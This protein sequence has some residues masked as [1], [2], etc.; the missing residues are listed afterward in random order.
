MLILRVPRNVHT[1]KTRP[2]MGFLVRTFIKK[3]FRVLYGCRENLNLSQY[4]KRSNS[5]GTPYKHR[6]LHFRPDP[7]SRKAVLPQV[8]CM[9]QILRSASVDDV[10]GATRILAW[11]GHKT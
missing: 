3:S 10:T 1:A 4:T 11:K 5:V 9:L 2:L 8:Y 6:V 7:T